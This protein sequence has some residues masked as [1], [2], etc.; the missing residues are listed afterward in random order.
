LPSR[1]RGTKDEEE[2]DEVYFSP[3]MI[4]SLVLA[5][6]DEF[7]F[8]DL[9][10][11][12]TSLRSAVPFEMRDGPHGVLSSEV[13]VREALASLLQEGLCSGWVEA[14]TMRYPDACRRDIPLRLRDLLADEPGLKDTLDRVLAQIGLPPTLR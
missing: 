10:Q 12:V 4:V 8:E 9:V 11:K 6:T 14:V 2:T 7:R 13:E 5:S 3:D 1:T